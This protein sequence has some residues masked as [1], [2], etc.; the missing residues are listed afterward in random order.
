MCHVILTGALV[1][2]WLQCPVGPRARSLSSVAH[3][4][5]VGVQQPAKGPQLHVDA[6]VVPLV[7]L[8][9]ILPL[10]LAN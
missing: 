4:S 5:H 6:G 2:V 3:G 7:V 8:V 9:D 1:S 10:T